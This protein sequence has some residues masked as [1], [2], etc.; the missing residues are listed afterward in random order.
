MKIISADERKTE[1]TGIKGVIFGVYGIGKTSLLLTLDPKKTLF[2]SCEAGD[3]AVLDYK[4]DTI[5][6]RDWKHCRDIAAVI[7]GVN[8]AM[9]ASEVYCQSHFDSIKELL[10][11]DKYETIF[12][13]SIT[14]ISRLCLHWS[15]SQPESVSEKTGKLDLRKAYGTLGQEMLAWCRHLQ[16]AKGKNIWFVSLLDEKQDEFNRLVRSPQ[17]EG[18]KTG[19][20]LP[21]IVDQVLTLA[22][23]LPEKESGK[24]TPFRAFVCTKPNPFG[25][26]AK[27]RSGKLD[28]IE[29][30]H[31]GSL[32]EKIRLGERKVKL[33]YE[34]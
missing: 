7:G 33:S 28:M 26:P 24:I 12:I 20:E 21:G 11:V 29:R 13:D 30:P 34:I 31:L 2:V 10:S 25:Y 3:E 22:E 19:L 1:K 4:G 23:I 32:M 17:I 16:H 9:G 18:Q 8:N 6:L 27:D 5:E 14:E 15:K